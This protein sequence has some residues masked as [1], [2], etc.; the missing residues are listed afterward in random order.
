MLWTIVRQGLRFTR[1][2]IAASNSTC[3]PIFNR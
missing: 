1:P 2:K 3:Y